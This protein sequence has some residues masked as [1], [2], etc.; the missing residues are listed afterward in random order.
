VTVGG[1][2][3]YDSSVGRNL[4]VVNLPVPGVGVQTVE[5]YL[6]GVLAGTQ[7]IDFSE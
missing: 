5:I 2:T 4:G 1:K 3:E 7:T 6:D